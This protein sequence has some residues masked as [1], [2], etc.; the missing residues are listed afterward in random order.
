[1]Q[2]E[3]KTILNRIQHLAGFVY[4]KSR[5]KAPKNRKTG[6]FG[7]FYEQTPNVEQHQGR[8]VL[9]PLGGGVMGRPGGQKSLDE[10][11]VNG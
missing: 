8:H 2:L 4:R 3:V 1:M 11:Q 10:A 5:Q 7:I 9:E 6:A